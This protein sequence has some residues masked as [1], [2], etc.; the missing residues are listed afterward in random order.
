MTD[1]LVTSDQLSI[2]NAYQIVLKR[3]KLQLSNLSSQQI[4][5]CRTYL[6]EKTAN[7]DHSFY[8][9]NTGFGV[10][11]HVAI[12]PADLQDLQRNLLLS[13]ACGM[14]SEVPPDL[15]RLMLLLKIQS[16]SYGYSGVQL[17]TVER[18]IALFNHNVLPVVYEQG[19]LG[20]SGD[21]APLAHLCL[22]L[23]GEGL[24]DYEG[25]TQTAA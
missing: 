19:S 15:V 6:D 7:P 14:G 25:K 8:G 17:T 11:C 16:L 20:A 3:S 10:L 9:I 22:P 23:I 18:L 13:H 24:V 12:P 4:Q 2:K 5:R 21:L 1:H